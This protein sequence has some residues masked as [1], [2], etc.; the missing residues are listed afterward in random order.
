MPLKSIKIRTQ[1]ETEFDHAFWHWARAWWTMKVD[2][3]PENIR[4]ERREIAYLS[5][6]TGVQPDTLRRLLKI[7]KLDP[8]S[9]PR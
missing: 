5:R 4:Q 6:T 9:G 7:L 8:A 3:I 1:P 2:S